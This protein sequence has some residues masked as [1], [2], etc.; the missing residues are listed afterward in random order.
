LEQ[1]HALV[2]ASGRANAGILIDT[3]HFD[4]SPSTLAQLAAIP[5]GLFHYAQLNDAPR[6]LTP[7]VAQMLYTARQERLYLGEGDIAVRDIVAH[8]PEIPLSLE[9]AHAKRQQELGYKEFA[10]LCLQ[11]ARSYFGEKG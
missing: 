3:L 4:R 8:L 1:A 2:K 7:T 5:S 11:K 9:I 10:R 6:I